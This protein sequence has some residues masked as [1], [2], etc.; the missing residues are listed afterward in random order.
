MDHNQGRLNRVAKG[1]A[2]PLLPSKRRNKGDESALLML[3]TDMTHI[4]F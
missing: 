3:S 2:A 4:F 1:E